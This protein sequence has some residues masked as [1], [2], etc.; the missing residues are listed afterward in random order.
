MV[1]LAFD[2]RIDNG[3]RVF[4]FK[5]KFKIFLDMGNIDK[6]QAGLIAFV[7]MVFIHLGTLMHWSVV[8]GTNE[9]RKKRKIMAV[10]NKYVPGTKVKWFKERM[11]FLV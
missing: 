10:Y 8:P 9:K 11:V 3:N 2:W 6:I 1:E 5:T 7:V 4:I